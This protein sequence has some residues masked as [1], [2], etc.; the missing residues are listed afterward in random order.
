[1]TAVGANEVS[2]QYEKLMYEKKMKNIITTACPSVNYLIEKYYPD[3]IDQMAPVVSPMIAHAKMMRET[4]G[5]R[6]RVVFIGPC[7]AKKDE[8]NDMQ[9]E[10]MVDAVLTFEEL[11]NWLNSEGLYCSNEFSEDIKASKDMSARIYP[12][13]GGILKTIDNKY[14]ANYKCISIDGAERCIEA[15]ESIKNGG[16]ENYFIEINSCQDGC[17]GGPC[18]SDIKGGFLVARERLINYV[19]KNSG[20]N[21]QL[22]DMGSNI[23]FRKKF[24]NRSKMYS[25][26]SEATV[27]AI[28]NSIGKFTKD[29]E[30]N[31][32]ACGYPTCRDKAVA[33][34][35]N[36]AQLH[37]CLPYM[38][39][40]AE[41]IS[42]LI[43]S[44]TPNAIF[45]LDNELRIQ[46]INTAARAKFQ[47]ADEDCIGE[48][49]YSL[50]PCED[51]INVL[52][53]RTS[54]Y[55][56]KY[57]Y[58]KYDMT[59]VQSII[60]NPDQNIIVAIIKDIS[61]EESFKQKMHQIQS[62]NVEL[63]QKVIEKQMIV[64]QEIASL[65]GETTAETKVA[66]TKL[67]KS[68]IAG[69]SEE[70]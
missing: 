35:N 27:Q 53:S 47:L 64:A 6:I 36:R 31:C 45:A 14:K 21:N 60:F 13:P 57:Y 70:K 38:R 52:D 18:M 12:V 42:N 43:L 58:D 9:N 55:D 11:A 68:I 34:Y 7:L 48:N 39:E 16:I 17:I 20:I 4:Y 61:E 2:R 49:I 50:L 40:R 1:E 3:L 63:A 56:K 5:Q 65:L 19:R 66:L 67:K 37:M 8:C 41:S 29:T 46:E 32:G 44:T 69:M 15:L 28:L 30:L 25:V 26:P 24:I 54:I 10:G 33:V 22:T 62:D 59:V 51:F 23:D